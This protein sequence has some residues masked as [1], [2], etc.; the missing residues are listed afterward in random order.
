MA[1]LAQDEK[2]RVS[3]RARAVKNAEPILKEVL[4]M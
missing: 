3:H 2:N 4:G 1:E